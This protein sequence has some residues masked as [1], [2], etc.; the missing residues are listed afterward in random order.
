MIRHSI[1]VF[2][3]WGPMINRDWLPATTEVGQMFETAELGQTLDR[4]SFN[5]RVPALRERL[6]DVQFRLKS[7]ALSVVV[8]I[9]GV[10]GAGKGETVNML[11]EWLDARGIAC[12]ALNKPTEDEQERPFFYRFWRQLPP[13]GSIGIFFGSWHSQPIV[14]Y[15]CG[16]STETGFENELN[17]I[18]EFERMLTNEGVLILKFWLHISKKQQRRAFK[19]LKANPNTAWRVTPQDWK[20]HKLYDDFIP[21]C[22]RALRRT[23]SGFAPWQVVEAHDHRYRHITVAESIAATIE[24]R[25]T[26]PTVEHAPAQPL[27]VPTAVNVINSLDLSLKLPTADYQRKLEKQQGKLGRLSRDLSGAG[28]SVVVVFEGADAG[29]KGGCIRRIAQSLDARFYRVIPIAAPTDE[30]RA[31]PYLWRFWR[32]LPRRGHFTIYDRSWYGRVLV[33][34]VEGFCAP[35]DWQRAYAEINSFEEQLVKSGVVLL[36]F[37]LAI[38]PAE[39]ARRFDER[40][41][42]GYKRYKLTDEDRRNRQKWPAYEASASEMIERTSTETAPWTLVEAE[43]KCYARIKVLKT[44]IAGLEI[45]LG[46]SD[47]EPAPS[48]PHPK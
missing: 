29:G 31:R 45:A 23:S 15:A 6:L 13:R 28:R 46:K 24:A 36:K 35:A 41:A 17:Q 9:G 40:E 7:S 3:P 21:I 44:C 43:D 47:S 16:R 27:P 37:W 42:T 18:V 1:L 22:S 8:I 33:E 25:L 4:A 38:S 11:L 48:R 39:Q 32:H 2:G 10:E 34:R 19:A 12:H 26:A 5:D 30:E 14:D 20:Y